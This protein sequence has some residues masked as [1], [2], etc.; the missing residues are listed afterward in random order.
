[1]S[2]YAT[3]FPDNVKYMVLVGNDDPNA[4]IEENAFDIAKSMHQRITYFISACSED[5]C[6]VPDASA[7]VMGLKNLVYSLGD[8]LDMSAPEVM[9]NVLTELYRDT[10]NAAPELCGYAED[11]DVDGFKEWYKSLFK[12]QETANIAGVTNPESQPTRGCDNGHNIVIYGNE[13]YCEIEDKGS[14]AQN[15]VVAQDYSFGAYDEDLFVNTL[16]E[17]N[18]KFPGAGT[19]QP[20]IDVLQWYSASYHWPSI[21]PLPPSGE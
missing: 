21:T 13:D 17:L 10:G 1:M 2:M 8:E 3:I 16:M 11:E 12:G 20:V 5:K 6:G 15:L 14:I 7:C 19:Q 9:R 18:R 4:D